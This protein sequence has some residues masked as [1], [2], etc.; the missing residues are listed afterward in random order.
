[1]S[2]G[3]A[4]N[5]FI[6]KLWLTIGIL[7]VVAAVLLSV[8]RYSL[9]YADRFHDDI[10]EQLSQQL[11]YPVTL[12]GL[13]ADWTRT[14]PTVVLHDLRLSPEVDSPVALHVERANLGIHFWQSLWNWELQFEHFSAM[15][16]EL[17][18]QIQRDGEVGNTDATLDFLEALFLRQL[19]H[20]QLNDVLVRFHLFEQA[21]REIQL[22]TLI[23]RQHNGNRQATGSFRIPNVTVN[24]LD[25]ILDVTG[26][27]FASAQGSLY[28]DAQNLDITPWIQQLTTTARFNRTAF[29]L[30]GWLDFS[31]GQFGHGQ[32]HLNQNVLSWERHGE[33]H[34][35]TTQPTSWVLQPEENGWLLNSQPLEIQLDERTWLIDSV[36]WQYRNGEHTWNTGNIELVDFSPL[37]SVFGSPGEVLAEWS[38]GLATRG[39][40]T[41]L[42]VRLTPEREW[43]F[44]LRADDLDWQPHR[45]VPGI[46]GL[47]LELWSSRRQG[48]FVVGG[49]E[50]RL[51]SPA[52]YNDDKALSELAIAG[53]W[54]Q[55]NGDWVF[56]IDSA[57]FGLPGA[58]IR[59]Q[60]RIS[61]GHAEGV[62]IDWLVVGGSHGMAVLDVVT[63]LPLQMGERLGQYL[64][65]SLVA[66]T[67]DDLRMVWRGPMAAFP[68][69]E[70]DGIFQAQVQMNDLGLKFQPNWPAIVGA[71]ADLRFVDQELHIQTRGGELAG[72]PLTTVNGVISGIIGDSEPHLH[73]ASSIV[74]EP[75]PLAD[76]FALS[77]LAGSVAATLREVQ[78]QEPIEGAFTLD[79]PLVPDSD[80]IAAGSVNFANHNIYLSS[81]DMWLRDVHGELSFDNA[82]IRFTTESARLF[83]QPATVDLTGGLSND[84][85]MLRA[86][87]AGLWNLP[88]L[89]QRYPEIPLLSR[90]GGEMDWTAELAIALGQEFQLEIDLDGDL[91]ASQ[92]NLPEPIA[93]VPG[94]ERRARLE[95]RIDDDDLVA[96]GRVADVLQVRGEMALSQGGFQ[97]LE[98]QLGASN[99]PVAARPAQGFQIFAGF[100]Q[101]DLG[102]WLPLIGELYASTT[103]EDGSVASVTLAEGVTPAEGEATAASET[104]TEGEAAGASQ[105]TARIPALTRIDANVTT[106][107]WLGQRFP[108][109]EITGRSSDDGWLI[110][111]TADNT[112]TR[113]DWNVAT[114]GQITVGAD[115]LLLSSAAR[116][117]TEEGASDDASQLAETVTSSE[118][119]DPDFLAGLPP[120]AFNCRTC[121]YDDK[122][123]GEVRLRLSPAAGGQIERFE[124]RRGRTVLAAQGGWTHDQG[125]NL[126]TTIR[127]SFNSNN[128]GAYVADM[129][130][131]SV[132]RDSDLKVEYQLN[133]PGLPTDFDRADLSGEVQWLLGP[134][135]LRDVP[136][137]ARIFSVLSLES[138]IRK[139]TLDFR[140]I[141]ARGM[142]YSSFGGTLNLQ[143]G[144]V[145]TDNT[146]MNGAAGDMTVSGTTNLATEAIHYQLT[147][148]PKVTSS[149]PV[150]LAFMVN[151][152]SGLAA[153][154]IDRML[155]DAQVISRLQYEVTGTMSD[156]VVNEVSRDSQEVE[157][158]ELAD[159]VLPRE[160]PENTEA[161]LER[162][163][164]QG[165]SPE[166]E[167]PE[168]ENN[169]EY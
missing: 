82:D 4:V 40:V 169:G 78:V 20:F 130:F 49:D 50:V 7:L 45:G 148:V 101:T 47:Q 84:E 6:A 83:G 150:L 165:D 104:I 138:V 66:G 25:F 52:T 159:E 79:I 61:N 27:T 126:R 166:S 161:E 96:L 143:D 87:L 93:H 158:P 3:K 36:L 124:M 74:A 98:I 155:H 55:N 134:G 117:D 33:E 34:E 136:D 139:F 62:A 135:Y 14:G 15:G 149:L 72:I 13:H 22:D 112:R 152:P 30:Q 68:Y 64:T 12:E 137:A 89:A 60:M 37:W 156:P 43:Q 70:G 128:I 127:G 29:N 153:L 16:A 103:D 86:D 58:E 38:E 21:P 80:V 31:E 19:D 65:D 97:A 144:V 147:Y 77:P 2:L 59:Q 54:L 75:Q 85:Y 131:T 42:Q 24:S 69:Q 111:L 44:H 8:V 168:S 107:H 46:S 10:A 140:D 109:S 132:V 100:E 18:I 163:R 145:S 41:D 151:P 105:A 154:L 17:D 129:G 9:P 76:M 32:L 1:M 122:D 67:V 119:F 121:R 90:L 160:L 26:D 53:G 51:S 99:Y 133:W 123:L 125:E 73:I 88:D 95:L 115:Y 167:S 91:A 157:L 94:N 106:L 39:V 118:V 81:V 108:N 142:F 11:G 114:P 28:V 5:F 35:L 113:V 56:D 110:D 120:I 57:T 116:G 48:N 141:F 63:L 102:D 23:W 164:T 92:F 71:Q 162:K 146:R